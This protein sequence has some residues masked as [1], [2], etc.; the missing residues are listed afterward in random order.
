MAFSI[1]QL[2]LEN[3]EMSLSEIARAVGRSLSR[4][5][6]TLAALRMVDVRR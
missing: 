1:A 2:L 3:G 6:H 5:S 4:V